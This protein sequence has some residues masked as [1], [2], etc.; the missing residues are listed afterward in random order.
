MESGDII[1]SRQT[2]W[3]SPKY[4]PNLFHIHCELYGMLMATRIRWPRKSSM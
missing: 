2:P 1:S 4:D 3:H